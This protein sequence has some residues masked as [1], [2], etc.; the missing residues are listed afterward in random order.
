MPE[1]QQSHQGELSMAGIDQAALEQQLIQLLRLTF[2]AR[3]E[4]VRKVIANQH[5]D[6]LVLILLLRHPSIKVVIKLAG[7]EAVMAATFDRTAMVHRFVATRTT[8]PMPEI[9]AV[10][11][12]CRMFPWRYLV[13]TYLSGREWWS[14]HKYLS[15]DEKIEVYRQIGNTV[16]QLHNIHFPSFGE[17]ALDGR[18]MDGTAFPNAF[19]RHAQK[20]ISSPRLREMFLS[21]VEKHATLFRGVTQPSLCHEDLHAHNILFHRQHGQ[22]RLATLLDFDKAWVGHHEIDLARMEFWRGVLGDGFW[23]A[24]KAIIPIDPAYEQR[25]PIYQLLWCLEFARPTPQH[26][27]DTLGLCAQLGL[28]AIESFD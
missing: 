12:S 4:P 6:Y 10:D 27:R 11:V 18:V 7:P 2:G 14:L 3:V 9:L 22:W 24:Y 19:N 13:K 25:R 16:A 23:P 8:I 15:A 28:P 20:L 26:F 1:V 5:H 17:L 21:L